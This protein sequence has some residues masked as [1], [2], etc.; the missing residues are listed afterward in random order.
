MKNEPKDG[1]RNGQHNTVYNRQ[2]EMERL[3]QREIGRCR[4][5]KPSP[6]FS[7]RNPTKK[8]T[9][10]KSKKGGLA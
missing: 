2:E 9:K 6:P 7:R 10:G 5:G 1:K 4:E 3:A 8:R